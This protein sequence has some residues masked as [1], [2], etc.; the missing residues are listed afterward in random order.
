MT[1]CPDSATAYWRQLIH[2]KDAEKAARE[3]ARVELEAQRFKD[4]MARETEVK[5]QQA[6]IEDSMNDSVPGKRRKTRATREETL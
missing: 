5:R 6:S 1:S 4:N 2:A 3:Q